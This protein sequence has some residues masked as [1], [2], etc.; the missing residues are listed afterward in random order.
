M[1]RRTFLA[2]GA[3]LGIAPAIGARAP[4]SVPS[5]ED[6]VRTAAREARQRLAFDGARFSGPS[7]DWLVAQ[8]RQSRF[9]ALGEEHGIAENP[10]LAAQLFR[11]LVPAGYRH[12]AIE[13]SPPM[14]AEI[15]RAAKQGM[16]ELGTFLT[17]RGQQVAFFG[18]REEA[19]WL[20]AARAA[21][22]GAEPVLWGTDYE[23]FADR[24]LIALLKRMRKPAAAEAAL[25][26]VEAA[27]SDAWARQAQTKDLLQI[28][29]FSGDPALVRALRAAWPKAGAQAGQIIDTLEET[30]EINGLYR[31]RQGY[32]S[33]ARRAAFLRAN[34]LRQWRGARGPRTFLKL[35]AN[36]LVRGLTTVGTFDIG[37]LIAELAEAQGEKSF[38][39]LVLPGNDAKAAV[40]DP[41]TMAYKPS[42]PKDMYQKGLGWMID[43]AWPD[44]FTLFDTHKLRPTV[45]SARV[46][47]P[48]L[49]R[50]V[51][52]YDAVLVMSGSTP[53]SNL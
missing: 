20:A 7:Y 41:V 33:N 51:F 2:A 35:G 26:R 19:E 39:L 13:I 50:T 3:A 27:S 44:S 31:S 25:A 1:D 42:A 47:D 9:F 14:A 11:D 34:F 28:F 22:P 6:R 43:E 18:M 38:H 53:S 17:T 5:P 15:D 4:T 24:H 21:V 12:A 40:F 30:L 46:A 37:S 10:K 49:A 16:P 48:E 36:H 32:A 8:G 52:G 23:V 29:P 45:Y